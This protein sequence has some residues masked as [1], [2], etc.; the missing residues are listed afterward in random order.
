MTVPYS[1]SNASDSIPLS[2]LDDNF[3]TP[4]T[5]GNASI[6]LWNNVSSIGNLTLSNVTITSENGNIAF[7]NVTVSLA[8]ITT[9]NIASLI[10]P[11]SASSRV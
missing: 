6:Q 2:Q 8:N 5:L 3:N 1:F 10:I 9:A 7:S 4:F 11:S